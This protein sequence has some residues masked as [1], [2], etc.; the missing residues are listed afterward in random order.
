M[1]GNEAVSVE[2]SAKWSTGTGLLPEVQVALLLT[3]LYLL[4]RPIDLS[5]TNPLLTLY[6]PFNNPKTRKHA[7]SQTKTA[8]HF[9]SGASAGTTMARIARTGVATQT[10]QT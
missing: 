4:N 9:K 2:T 6:S 7:G 5:S 8:S 10:K 3:F 1:Q